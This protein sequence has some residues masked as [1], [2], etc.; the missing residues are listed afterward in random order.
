MVGRGTAEIY[1]SLVTP[2]RNWCLLEGV[3]VGSFITRGDLSLLGVY[4]EAQFILVG[5][6]GL[7]RFGLVLSCLGID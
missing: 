5:W 7:V 4:G 2:L 6:L 1:I 3:R